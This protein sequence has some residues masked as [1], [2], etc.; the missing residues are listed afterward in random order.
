MRNFIISLL[1]L[2]LIELIIFLLAG[3]IIGITET[4]IIVIGTGILGGVLLK[5]QGL[6]A[7][8]NVQVQLNQGIMP[9]D[10]ILDSFCVLVGG[11]LLLFP[12]FL[13]DIVGVIIL[14]PPTRRIGKN[15]LMRSI[16]RK[17]QK[18]NRV[19]IIH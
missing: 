4:L 18:K 15:L 7:I 9:G 17:L 1:L 14:F 13:T 8:R 19:T 12:G 3:N 5:K 10:A 2:P 11:L 6:K 16:Q